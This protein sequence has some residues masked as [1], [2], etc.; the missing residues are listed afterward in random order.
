MRRIP[1]RNK[2][3]KIV[4]WAAVDDADYDS[5][6]EYR[7]HPCN[8]YAY[9]SERMH[10]G[11][12]VNFAMHREIMK[13]PSGAEIDHRDRR[14]S[15]NVRS[16]LRICTSSQNKCNSGRDPRNTSG[17]RGVSWHSRKRRWMVKMTVNRKTIFVGSFTKR[18][19]AV[20]ARNS[21]AKTIHGEFAS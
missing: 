2:A 6:K 3:N 11:K 18:R 20:A 15:N 17:T 8:G 10:S 13:P 21:A 14:R 4:R 7:W 9:R 1:L 5:L 12:T 19:A 16:N